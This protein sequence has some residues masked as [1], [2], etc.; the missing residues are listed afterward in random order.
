MIQVEVDVA[1]GLHFKSSVN[2]VGADTLLAGDLGCLLNIAGRL[3]RKGAGVRVFHVAEVL[4]GMAEGPGIG[5]GLFRL[6]HRLHA[7]AWTRRQP[8]VGG[9]VFSKS[10]VLLFESRP[11]NLRSTEVALYLP[12]PAYSTLGS[13]GA[14]AK[15]PTALVLK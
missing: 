2:A 10:N 12:M 1:A 9:C 15:A 4:A 6:Y 7:G 3:G 13:E 5:G 11:G 8:G 14:M